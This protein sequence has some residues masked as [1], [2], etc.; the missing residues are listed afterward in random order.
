MAFWS[1]SICPDHGGSLAGWTLAERLQSD[2]D[3][4]SQRSLSHKR[5]S[6]CSGDTARSCA[7]IDCSRPTPSQPKTHG[8]AYTHTNTR[9]HNHPTADPSANGG[10]AFPYCPAQQYIDANAIVAQAY[11]LPNVTTTHKHAYQ[12]VD[13]STNA[14]R[15]HKLTRAGSAYTYLGPRRNPLIWPFAA[16]LSLRPS[17]TGST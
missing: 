1:I 10:A 7:S 3:T 14:A 15:A 11:Q 5:R 17:G 8:H 9:L 16:R 6:R 13:A 4:A 2:G 12:H